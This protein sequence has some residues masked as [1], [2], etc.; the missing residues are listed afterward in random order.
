MKLQYSGQFTRRLLNSYE[1][2]AGL[3]LVSEAA[4]YIKSKK[5]WLTDVFHIFDRVTLAG[6]KAPD[7]TVANTTLLYP[8]EVY[9]ENLNAMYVCPLDYDLLMSLNPVESRIT[10]LL[11]VKFYGHRKGITYRYLT[12]CGLLPI[13]PQRHFSK[14]TEKLNPRLNNLSRLNVLQYAWKPDPEGA[15]NWLLHFKPGERTLNWIHLIEEEKLAGR[16]VFPNPSSVSTIHEDLELSTPELVTE[17]FSETSTQIGWSLYQNDDSTV[18]QRKVDPCSPIVDLFVGAVS[19]FPEFKVD[20]EKD[21]EWFQAR[22]EANPAYQ[23][24]DLQEEILDWGDWLETQHRLKEAPKSNRFPKSDFRASL[25]NWLKNPSLGRA[26]NGED[27]SISAPR[28]R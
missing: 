10:E 20:P 24:L 18:V 9:L 26:K 16:I 3:T 19:Q 7:G 17:Q 27:H 12:F 1:R 6:K 28:R 8:S 25:T 21:R 15:S 4:I 22:I 2:L 14:A 13:Q 11:T 23:D 5:E